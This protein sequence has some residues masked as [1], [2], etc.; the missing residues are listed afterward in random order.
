M[1]PYGVYRNFKLAPFDWRSARFQK[2]EFA[3]PTGPA[4]HK[5]S[6]NSVP[7]DEVL[8]ALKE[9]K[10]S[11][12]PSYVPG[13]FINI[14]AVCLLSDQLPGLI[15]FPAVYVDPT[16]PVYLGENQIPKIWFRAS[17]LFSSWVQTP[18]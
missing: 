8:T 5:A 2:M 14:S 11:T 13:S 6:T 18:R 1:Y 3:M 12:P 9:G 15:F 7:I 17:P 16:G 4:A 10:T